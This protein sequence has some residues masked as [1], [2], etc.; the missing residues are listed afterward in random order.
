MIVPDNK[1]LLYQGISREIIN[2]TLLFCGFFLSKR[3]IFR[4]VV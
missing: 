1:I 2:D 3:E 4:S